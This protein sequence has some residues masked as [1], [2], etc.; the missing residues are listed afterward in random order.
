MPSHLL[1]RQCLRTCQPADSVLLHSPHSLL[2]FQLQG[3]RSFHRKP[4]VTVFQGATLPPRVSDS[5]SSRIS[6]RSLSIIKLP[7]RLFRTK[8]STL[9]PG[10]L[11]CLG[12][13]C[14]EM[15]TCGRGGGGDEGGGSEGISDDSIEACHVPELVDDWRRPAARSN[16]P[17]GT[18][19]R[20][21]KWLE[22]TRM[23]PA[24]CARQSVPVLMR[25]PHAWKREYLY[26]PEPRAPK[27]WAGQLFR[28][29]DVFV[30]PWGRVFNRTHVFDGGK[31]IDAFATVGT[32]A[33]R[34]LSLS[35][36]HR[37]HTL[38][39]LAASASRTERRDGERTEGIAWVGMR[40]SGSTGE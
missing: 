38:F 9:H 15:S 12:G 8:G 26:R 6:G 7:Y 33:I 23:L 10:Q 14:P 1:Q 21:M 39:L 17:N 29:H 4:E 37:P 25:T 24:Q 35:S 34:F 5:L 18:C 36:G 13:I 3:T 31:C 16:F 2:P 27:L 32:D 11:Q 30:D 40:C 28:L 20:G 22:S 19:P